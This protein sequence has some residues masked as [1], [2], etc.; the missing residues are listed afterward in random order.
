MI[1]RTGRGF[2]LCS[3]GIHGRSTRQQ[4]LVQDGDLYGALPPNL[5]YDNF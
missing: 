1:I 3:D 5:E 2:Q 4:W